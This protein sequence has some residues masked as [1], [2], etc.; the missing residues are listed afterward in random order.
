MH[1]S[2]CKSAAAQLSQTPSKLASPAK[3]PVDKEI[4]SLLLG[5]FSTRNTNISTLP[6]SPFSSRYPFNDS[7]HASLFA[8]ISR[9]QFTV[10]DCLS[11][12]ARCMI[13]ALLRREP[14]E[15][16]ASEDVLFHPWLQHDDTREQLQYVSR[17]S[18]TGS[19]SGA[20]NAD[21]QCVPEWFD[22]AADSDGDLR[23]RD[24]R[25]EDGELV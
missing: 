14:E 19:G 18:G 7:E 17:S 9:G 3:S 22:P 13:R 16:I 4:I 23:K 11:S 1:K 6:L 21:D 2:F 12:K 5:N 15:R 10:P 20:A 24:L 25:Y 8:K